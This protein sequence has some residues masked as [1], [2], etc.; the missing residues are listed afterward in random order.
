VQIVV[1]KNVMVVMRDGVA[2]ATDVYRPAGED[3]LPAVLV[4]TPYDKE[5]SALRNYSFEVM[6]LVQA[7]YVVVVQDTRGRFLSEGE[8][9]PFF[10]DGRDGF[11]T[12]AWVAEQE[13]CDGNVGMGGGSYFGATQ[14]RAASE[15]PPALKAIAPVVTAADYHEGWAYQGGAFEL[16]FNLNW[17]LSRL[18]LGEALERGWS[19]GDVIAAIDDNA[20]LYERL[21]LTDQP[22]LQGGLA[23]YYFDWLAHP[24]YDDYWREIAPKEHYDKVTIP[25]LNIGGWYDLFI[26]GTIANYVAMKDRGARLVI[27]PWAHGDNHGVFFGREYGFVGGYWGTDPTALHLRWFDHH[28][29]GIDNGVQMDLPVR[30]FVMGVDEWRNERD[31]PLP[32][33][34]F[35]RYFLRAGGELSTEMP[36]AE[37]HET[38][39]YD[40]LDPVPTC[41]GATFLPG[42]PIAAN[43]GP[44]DQRELDGRHDVLT[45]AT[46]PLERD[47]EVT[48]PVKLVLFASS[49]AR[50]TDFTGKLVDVH[51]DGR[52]ELLTDGI[53]RAR[54]RDSTSEPSLLEPGEIY[55]LEIDLWATANV[56]KA[57]HRIRLDVSSSNFP[58]FD[59][60][61]N[62]GNV[63]ADDGAD[64]VLE[65]VNRVYH[66]REHPSH[67]LLPLIPR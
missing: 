12:V 48:G 18:A 39:V 38:Y 8:F 62:T 40:P 4:R 7:G 41:G 64:D 33:T 58:R 63:I 28:L 22:A 52:A 27:G 65:A 16:G 1:D 47:T 9:N 67:V 36:G 60:N 49:S 21:P 50:D 53:L 11:D 37:R 31:W 35:T 55:E 15:A 10:D 34:R 46:P 17:T 45:F 42:L 14:W 44:R 61:T 23:P 57:G 5:G 59:R 3:P 43:A 56:F 54:Y 2:L 26:G 29:K 20:A 19:V 30:I 24:D 66:D 25:S 6:R 32:G 51:P 13:W